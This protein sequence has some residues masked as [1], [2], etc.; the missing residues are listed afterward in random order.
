M[1]LNETYSRVQLDKNLSDMF[2]MRN[3]L[4]QGKAFSSLLFSFAL[5]YAIRRVEVTNIAEM[6]SINFFYADDVNR[7]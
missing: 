7:Y 3:G 6:K 1:C 2:H 5:E 4:K